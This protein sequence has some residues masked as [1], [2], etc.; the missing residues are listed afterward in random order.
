MRGLLSGLRPS[1]L[2]GPAPS[3]DPTDGELIYAVGDIHG[4]YDLMKSLLA[5]VARDAAPRAHG[6]QPLLIF[7][8]DYIDRGPQSAQVLEALVWLR[9]RSDMQVHL[10]KGNHEQTMLQFLERPLRTAAW[11]QFGGAQT[12]LSYGVAPPAPPDDP[13]EL[14]RARNALLERMPSSHLL[15]LERL[16][17]ML[18]IGD[19]AFVHAGV[20][21]DTP[22]GNQKEEDL[23]WINGEFLEQEGP[24]EKVIVHGHTWTDGHP[25]L[26]EHRIGLDTGAYTTGVLTAVR[27]DGGDVGVVQARDEAASAFAPTAAGAAPGVHH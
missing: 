3:S 7:C 16:E 24:F 19:Y 27:L 13:A 14:V 15:L 4:R 9:K 23:L 26:L 6:R 18:V 22:L 10:L 2:G 11:Q 5:A 17:L 1:W 21:P 12:L 25:A 8:G 20:R